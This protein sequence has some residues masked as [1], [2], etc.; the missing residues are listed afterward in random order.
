MQHRRGPWS[1]H[2]DSQLLNLVQI[3][4]PHNWVRISQMVT[5]RS[6]KQ[7]RERYHQNLKP[8]LNH[9]P[10]TPEEGELIERLVGDMGKRWAEIARRLHGRSDNAVKNWWNGGMNRRRRLCIR[11]RS[12]SHNPD[13]RSH[14]PMSPYSPNTHFHPPGLTIDVSRRTLDEPL[15][16]PAFSDGSR[17]QTPSLISDANSNFSTSPRLPET[18]LTAENAIILPP[19]KDLYHGERRASMPIL[20]SAASLHIQEHSAY[21]QDDT[22][23]WVSNTDSRR[24]QDYHTQYQQHYEVPSSDF[25][26]KLSNLCSWVWFTQ[27]ERKKTQKHNHYIFHSNLTFYNRLEILLRK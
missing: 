12:E 11:Q 6:P 9:E 24:S 8:T 19:L 16:S 21:T 26:M 15:S 17:G 23:R 7:C 10:I 2:E 4:G 27:K 14:E 20:K 13:R 25:R 18:P 22:R 5:S 1:A 3:H